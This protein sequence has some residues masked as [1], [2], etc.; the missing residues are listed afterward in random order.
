MDK[1]KLDRRSLRQFGITMAIAFLIITLIVLIRH[2]YSVIATSIISIT[3]LILAFA[4][5]A[6]LKPIYI[7]WMK[8]A[9]VLGWINTRLILFILFYLLFTPI[10]LVMRLFKVDLLERK[11]EKNKDSYWKK[12]EK[13]EFNLSNYERQF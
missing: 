4:S 5:P 11:I 1:L 3:F 6:L 12:K 7:L 13:M 9:F 10:G 8:L 2:K